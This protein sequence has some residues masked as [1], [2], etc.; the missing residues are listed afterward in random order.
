MTS[1]STSTRTPSQ[2]R[3]RVITAGLIIGGLLALGGASSAGAAAPA[4]ATVGGKC[5]VTSGANAGKSGTYTRDEYGNIWCEGSWGGTQCATRCKN[6][7]AIRM[8]FAG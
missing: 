3:R 2:A 1:T 4:G 7:L 8:Q 6:A 5:T